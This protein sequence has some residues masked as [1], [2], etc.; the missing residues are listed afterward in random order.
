MLKVIKWYSL[1]I[2][3]TI[4]IFKNSISINPLYKFATIR[5]LSYKNNLGSTSYLPFG[6]NLNTLAN[7]GFP[8][9]VMLRV[10]CGKTL[11][12]ACWEEQFMHLLPWGWRLERMPVILW[13]TSW[14]GSRWNCPPNV[15]GTDKT[16]KCMSTIPN[17][18][19]HSTKHSPL[20]GKKKQSDNL[21]IWQ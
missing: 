21:V 6:F 4:M 9:K 10:W 7:Q 1:N 11:G 15:Q 16:Q 8:G 2:Y 14:Q 17:L 20:S 5:S 12:R 3:F 13:V 19:I 18:L